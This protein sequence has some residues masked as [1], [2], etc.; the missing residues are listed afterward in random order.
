MVDDDRANSARAHQ[1]SPQPNADLKSLDRL[2]G[3]WEMSGG[4]AS[5][6]QLRL[7]ELDA[8]GEVGWLKALRLD[9]HV[10]RR[11]WRPATL[12]LH[13]VLFAYT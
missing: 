8:L 7:F 1:Q 3:T 11:S 13:E 6:A 9:E 10:P 2:V 5:P 12:T 4:R